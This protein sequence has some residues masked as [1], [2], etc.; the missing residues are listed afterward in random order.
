MKVLSVVCSYPPVMGGMGQAAANYKK[1][2]ELAGI[3]VEIA[4]LT[5]DNTFWHFGHAGRIKF[6]DTLIQNCD[7]IHFHYP[8]FGMHGVVLKAAKKFNKPIVASYHM[9]V[10]G[11]WYVRLFFLFYGKFITPKIIGKF[12]HTISASLDY[13]N[14]S[15]VGKF[16]KKNKNK[17]SEV[18]FPIEKEKFNLPASS[19]SEE[20]NKFRNKYK[21]GNCVVLGFLS[22]LDSAHYF[23]G[24]NVLLGAISIMKEKG[25]DNFV[26]LVGGAGALKEK[27]EKKVKDLGLG[28][29][30]IF[31]GF[32][33]EN[34]K[35]FFL[36]NLDIFILPSIDQ[37]EAFGIVLEEALASGTRILTSDMPGI[38]EMAEFA[39]GI[40][41]PR[42]NPEHLATV[43]FDFVVN[44]DAK[45]NATLRTKIKEEALEKFEMKAIGEQLKKIYERTIE[46][47]NK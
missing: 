17:V 31:L 40:K 35:Q 25:A 28:K 12:D 14:E 11:K 39:G 38:R 32:I 8:F 6:F 18:Y 3:D 30:V 9:D 43:L 42:N 45:E 46:E 21:I 7:C 37:S 10:I 20:K 44:F 23:K 19:T 27:Y 13:L 4:T 1:A 16:Y 15:F 5:K 29:Y 41:V 36:L 24:L 34:E 2:A 33:P 47:K 22:V 26:L